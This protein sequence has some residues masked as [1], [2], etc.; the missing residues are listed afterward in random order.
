VE[1]EDPPVVVEDPPVVVEA[2]ADAGDGS[3]VA[4]AGVGAGVADALRSHVPFPMYV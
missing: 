2:G 3:G 4:D 1:V